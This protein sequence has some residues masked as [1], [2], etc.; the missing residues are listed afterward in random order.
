MKFSIVFMKYLEI[1]LY[2]KFSK[3]IGKTVLSSICISNFSEQCYNTKIESIIQK[4]PYE[5]S[6]HAL[7]TQ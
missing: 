4:C 1:N 2:M 6:E 3:Q 7:Q 5:Q